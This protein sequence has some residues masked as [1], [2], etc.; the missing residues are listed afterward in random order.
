MQQVF[1]SSPFEDSK[2]KGI[3]VFSVF[4]EEMYSDNFLDAPCDIVLFDLVMEPLPFKVSS[5]MVLM[6]LDCHEINGV[7]IT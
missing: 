5:A 4:L 2:A 1:T 3:L 6:T 7:M